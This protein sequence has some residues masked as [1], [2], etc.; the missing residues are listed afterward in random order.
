MEATGNLICHICNITV[1]NDVSM[2]EHM[3]TEH[4]N[5]TTGETPGSGKNKKPKDFIK[6]PIAQGQHRI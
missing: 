2:V 6:D 5:G 3:V 4:S 1:E